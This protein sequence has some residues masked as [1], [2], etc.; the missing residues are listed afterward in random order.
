MKKIIIP[1]IVLLFITSAYPQTDIKQSSS[2]SSMLQLSKISVTVGGDFLV[3]GS[4]PAFVSER[5][6]E[7]VT[8]LY[9]QVLERGIGNITDPIVVGQIE[10]RL[11]QFSLRNITIKHADGTQ[12]IIDLL[13]F[14]LTGDF[15]DNPYLKNDDVIIF[16]PYNIKQNFFSVTGAVNNPGSFSYMEGDSLSDALLFA[17]GIN[18]SYD[19]VNGIVINRIIKDGSAIKS[20]TVGINDNLPLR[21][22]DRIVVLGKESGREAHNVLVVGEVNSPGYVPITKDGTTL[23]EVIKS[24]GGFKESASL[25]RARIYSGNSVQ[26]LLE[27]EYGITLKDHPYVLDTKLN[28]ALLKLEDVMMLRMS[29]VNE[30]DSAYFYIEN[31][32][33]V[34]NEGSAV[35]FRKLNDTSSAAS[36]YIVHDGDILI[37]PQKENSVYV[38]GQVSD[39]GH[40]PYEQGKDYKYYIE[41]AGGLGQY[42]DTPIMVIKSRS[43]QWLEADKP[44]VK[45]EDGDYVWVPRIPTHSFNWYVA[46]VG[47]YL[48]I[49]ASAATIFLLLQKL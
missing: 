48:G 41:K 32:M 14:R 47:G 26:L 11:K 23:S 9:N 42:A 19:D 7:L 30:Q 18:K 49:V 38:Y 44:G 21:Q 28:D 45:V 13:K 37:I 10:K 33:R 15:K 46:A 16:P 43:R 31:R 34:L 6:D 24:A 40:V 20:D 12:Q 36:K 25:R 8:Q 22:G 4:F 1:F 39:P 17:R 3:T 5:V 35:D 27:K 29:N 2:N